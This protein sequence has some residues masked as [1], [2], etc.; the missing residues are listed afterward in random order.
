MPA[1]AE[2]QVAQQSTFATVASWIGLALLLALLAFANWGIAIAAVLGLLVGTS[3]RHLGWGGTLIAA[4]VVVLMAFCLAWVVFWVWSLLTFGGFARRA[5][6]SDVTARYRGTAQLVSS[7]HWRITDSYTVD[8]GLIRRVTAELRRESESRKDLP[9]PTERR[10]AR[11]LAVSFTAAGWQLAKRVDGA[12]VYERG[13]TVP[14]KL[15]RWPLKTV[16]GI[17]M[18]GVSLKAPLLGV[19]VVS[20]ETSEL[21]LLTPKD[22]IAVTTPK[23]KS[24]SARLGKDL[25]EEVVLP[26]GVPKAS[27]EVVNPVAR[28]PFGQALMD[29]T[30]WGFAKWIVFGFFGLLSAQLSKHI[31]EPT[32]G[33]LLRRLKLSRLPAEKPAP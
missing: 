30:F 9:K 19:V 10:A 20:S 16:N 17:G 14:V 7:E 23:E 22:A 32:I 25:D 1:T 13:R 27:I 29:V 11:L 26:A 28:N 24:R 2:A 33:R 15:R 4:A 6:E 3:V 8:N 12:D 21:H 31:L 5:P 18:P